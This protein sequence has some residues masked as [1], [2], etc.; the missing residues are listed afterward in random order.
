MSESDDNADKPV[1]HR[2]PLL[3]CWYPAVQMFY[4]E[5]RDCTSGPR[6][7]LLESTRWLLWEQRRLSG[8]SECLKW[9]HSRN[10]RWKD[11]ACNKTT[12]FTFMLQQFYLPSL[13]EKTWFKVHFVKILPSSGHILDCGNQ[14]LNLPLPSLQWTTVAS[15]HKSKN[16]LH[17]LLCCCDFTLNMRHASRCASLYTEPFYGWNTKVLIQN[18][19]Y[20]VIN[21]FMGS[22]LRFN[23]HKHHGWETFYTLDFKNH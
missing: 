8:W 17:L 6:K 19:E 4:T 1:W 14:Y 10:P 16:L 3:C 20:R 7:G 18:C 12:I 23:W 15:A 21:V 13:C 5:H 2:H 9:T 11:F 22:I